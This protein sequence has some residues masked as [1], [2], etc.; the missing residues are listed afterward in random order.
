[1]IYLIDTNIFLRALI[2]EN[3]VTFSNCSNFFQL[4]KRNQIEAAA[5]GIVLAEITWTLGFHYKFSRE[6]IFRGLNSIV[7]L[8]GLRIVDNYNYIAAIDLFATSS[9]KYVDCLLA[10]ID[11][12]AKGLWTVVS[13]DKDFDRLK[14]KRLEPKDIITSTKGKN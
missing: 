8:H 6:R 5:C 1:M 12:V 9:A 11:E 14:V 13:Y 3:P 4:V 10:T 2:E 7:N